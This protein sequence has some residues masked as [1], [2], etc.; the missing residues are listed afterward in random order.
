MKRDGDAP[1]LC[2]TCRHAREIQTRRGPSYLLCN[3]SLTDD[4][5]AR[6]PR[7]PVLECAGHEREDARDS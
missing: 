4:R 3:R 5:Y 2:S 7:L 6:Y 1:G